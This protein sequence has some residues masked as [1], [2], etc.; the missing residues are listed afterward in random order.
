MERVY[1]V[2]DIHGCAQELE[3]LV[4]GLPLQPDDRLVFLGDYIDR[5]PG[6]REVV[7]FLLRLKAE[8]N[9]QLTCLKGNH[10]DMFLDFLGKE[11]HFGEG[12]L[13]NGGQATLRSYRVPQGVSGQE[14]A[15]RLPPEH[16]QF[17]QELETFT[18]VDKVLCV[19]AGVN[20][21][22]PLAEQTVEEMLWIRQEFL[23]NTHLL[24]YTVVFGHTPHRAVRFELPYKVGLDTGLVYGGKLSCLEV[25]EKQL[26]QVAKGSPRV[27]VSDVTS[28]W[29]QASPLPVHLTR[30]R[31]AVHQMLPQSVSL[32]PD[33]FKTIFASDPRFFYTNAVYEEAYKSILNA[34]RERKGLIAL[35]GKPGTGKTKLIHLLTNSLEETVHEV[36]CDAPNTTFEM[37]LSTLCDQLS[38]RFTN[39]DDEKVKLEAIEDALWAWT[40]RGGTEVLVLDNAHNL[41][42][43]ALKKLPQLLDLEGPHGKLLQIV[44]VARPELEV[45]LGRKEL[46]WIQ[47]RLAVRCRVTPLRKK[48]IDIFIHHRFRAAGWNQHDL[49]A[50]EV[51]E[52]IAQHSE[53][54]PQQINAICNNAMVAAY[55]TGQE[56]ISPHIIEEMVAALKKESGTDPGAETGA[57]Q[58][59]FQIV[60]QLRRSSI[61]PSQLALWRLRSVI[62]RMNRRQIIGATL[63]LCIVVGLTLMKPLSEGWWGNGSAGTT[64]S[65]E[66][67]TAPSPSKASKASTGQNTRN[68]KQL[69][70]QEP[71][72]ESVRQGRSRETDSHTE[73]E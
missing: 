38:L 73:V 15:D 25:T 66:A 21:L 44:L 42:P 1:I 23:T 40:Y 31:S 33:V 58:S 39:T 41:S 69:K 49:F 37:L 59:L 3:V 63:V 5:G 20:P 47:E 19:H 16:L 65:K 9:Y 45:K 18:V 53:A 50:P 55:A 11:G 27:Q 26:Y 68:S 48:E 71:Q 61:S 4:A 43:E 17:F 22:L 57:R 67:N 64:S 62:A 51:I 72:A 13:D 34:I 70:R 30:V 54:V 6:S 60:Q 46:R 52:M 12:F 8:R 10:E 56:K 14:V 36:A 28:A 35:L 32:D 2:G 24:P 29:A 7:D